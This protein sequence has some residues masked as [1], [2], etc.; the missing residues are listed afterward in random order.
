MCACVP[1][2]DIFLVATKSTAKPVVVLVVLDV[3]GDVAP[4]DAAAAVSMLLVGVVV[5]AT[6]A[7]TITTGKRSPATT[8]SIITLMQQQQPLRASLVVRRTNC[9]R[10]AL[11]LLR[12]Q[13]TRRGRLDVVVGAHIT[14]V[15]VCVFWYKKEGVHAHE[16]RKTACHTSNTV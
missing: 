12:L 13:P 15:C 8:S 9:C 3:V 1:S 14:C 7:S 5:A 2:T 11:L 6:A 4:L 16:E 10:L